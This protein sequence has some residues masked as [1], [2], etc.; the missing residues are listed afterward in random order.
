VSA[1]PAPPPLPKGNLYAKDIADVAH[2]STRTAE[3]WFKDAEARFGPALVLRDDSKRRR[4]YTTRELIEKAIK[5]AREPVSE[6]RH[7]WEPDRPE[8][9]KGKGL[10]AL[11]REQSRERA[12]NR[13]GRIGMSAT[14]EAVGH[15]FRYEGKDRREKGDA[16]EHADADLLH[17]FRA[18]ARVNRAHRDDPV[19][20]PESLKPE[21]LPKA[22]PKRARR[23]V[24][25]G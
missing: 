7:S 19:P 16:I 20:A 17:F 9:P 24:A 5:N 25:T 10:N 14:R 13:A 4:P 3:R 22:P 21:N 6:W 15:D 18:E 8:Q 11:L 23:N 1:R 2:I 12:L